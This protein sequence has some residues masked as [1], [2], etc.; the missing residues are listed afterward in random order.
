MSSPILKVS[1]LDVSY[2]N[3]GKVQQVIRDVNFE[4]TP[5]SVL[6]II[7]ESGAGK[8]SLALALMGLHDPHLVNVNGEVIFQ[9]QDLLT[10]GEADLCRV[11]GSGIGM[12]FQDPSGALDPAMRVDDQVAEAIRLHGTEDRKESQRLAGKYLAEVGITEDILEVAPYAHQLSGGL[13]QR[14]MIAAAT[15]C[16]PEILIADEPTSS[17]DVTL[18]AQII[19]LL[20]VRRR[21]GLAIIFISHDLAL[22][23]SFAD[24]IMVLFEG[25]VVE[26]GSCVEVMSRPRHA[27]TIDLIS[28]WKVNQI[29]GGS[30]HA[31]A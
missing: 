14:A 13:C 23:S 24:E 8:S 29:I 5:G 25:E 20:N 27:Y 3:G 15:A 30:A 11:R 1:N 31:P 12:I 9:S 10:L 17:L 21:A 28:F 2:V 26:S 6:G 18:Q 22:V 16:N 19:E 7:G 4:I